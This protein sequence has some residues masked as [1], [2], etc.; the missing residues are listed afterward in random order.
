MFWNARMATDG[1]SGS[2]GASAK[3]LSGRL[4]PYRDQVLEI[5]DRNH[6]GCG[7]CGNR[8]PYVRR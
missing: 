2:G 7:G 5:T 1:L 6:I 8:N 4:F 3:L